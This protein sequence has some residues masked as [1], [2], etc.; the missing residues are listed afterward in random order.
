VATVLL[1]LG[2]ADPMLTLDPTPDWLA[3]A[4]VAVTLAWFALVFAGER[5]R[6]AAARPAVAGLPRLGRNGT[7]WIINTLLSPLVVLPVTA[8]AA[9]HRAEWRPEWW[10]GWTGF[11]LDVIL[12]DFLIYWWHQA[13]H[14]IPFLWR[15]HEVHHLD[16]F[17]D[18]TSAIRFHFGEV[19]LSAGARAAVILVLGFP[20][21]SV[22]AFEALLLCATIFHHSNLHL[23]PI[24]ESALSRA[25]ITPSIHWVHHH[26]VRSDTDSNYGT[27]FSFWDRLFRTRSP[28]IRTPTMSIGVEGNPERP[29]PALLARPFVGHK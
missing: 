5:L 6:P 10:S 7:F 8:W 9:T 1:P 3:V 16:R 24:V 29:L 4:K 2:T 21:A 12:L 28:T 14:R 20:F 25:I 19:L 27:L 13:N 23:P 11:A 26:D 15:F 18:S 17:L 22:L